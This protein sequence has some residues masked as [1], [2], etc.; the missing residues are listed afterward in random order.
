[1]KPPL[2]ARMLFAPVFVTAAVGFVDHGASGA[3]ATGATGSDHACDVPLRS[4]IARCGAGV[5]ERA[6]TPPDRAPGTNSHT[7]C[8][9]VV[10]RA[11]SVAVLPQK[12]RVDW[13][14]LLRGW[15]SA[16]TQRTSS[17]AQQGTS[18]RTRQRTAR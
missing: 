16:R 4:A 17:A 1:M 2:F 12:K 6:L 15:R 13:L 3:S 8:R 11:F 7:R 18:W 14:T 5:V 10:H 9:R